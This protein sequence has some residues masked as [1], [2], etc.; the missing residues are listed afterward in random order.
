MYAKKDLMVR[1]IFI[2]DWGYTGVYGCLHK[3]AHSEVSCLTSFLEMGIFIITG[4]EEDARGVGGKLHT[5]VAMTAQNA[6]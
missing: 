4:K 5:T 3:V 1:R 6:W 2:S